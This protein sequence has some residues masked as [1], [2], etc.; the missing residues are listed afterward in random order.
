MLSGPKEA[1]V[2]ELH[3]ENVCEAIT[4]IN[5]SVVRIANV[6]LDLHLTNVSVAKFVN[7]FVSMYDRGSRVKGDKSFWV[8]I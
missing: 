5:V 8:Y 2:Q 6:F 4:H 7:V 3:F 1:G